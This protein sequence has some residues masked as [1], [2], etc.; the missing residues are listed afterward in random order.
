VLVVG[1]VGI[2]AFVRPVLEASGGMPDY[3]LKFRELAPHMQATDPLPTF[4]ICGGIQVQACP[5]AHRVATIGYVLMEPER[6][7]SL[8]GARCVCVCVCLCVCV[9]VCVVKS[10]I[11]LSSK[12]HNFS[13]PNRARELGVSGK[14][15]GL[16][17]AGQDVTLPNGRRIKSSECCGAPQRGEQ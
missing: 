17:K 16:L 11:S 10:L 6:P 7:G 12:E 14:A 5:L 9:F 8:D 4:Q 3:P 13:T 1:P 2:E 15:L